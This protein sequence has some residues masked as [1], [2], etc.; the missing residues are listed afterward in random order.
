M[1]SM[2]YS[3]R[4]DSEIA[5]LRAEI[6][7]LKQEQELTQRDIATL[8]DKVE[9]LEKAVS[10]QIIGDVAALGTDIEVLRRDQTPIRS[11]IENLVSEMKSLKKTKLEEKTSSAEVKLDVPRYKHTA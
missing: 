8:T 5:A 11:E 6:E 2:L 4:K 9:S 3:A 1:A 10:S 7:A